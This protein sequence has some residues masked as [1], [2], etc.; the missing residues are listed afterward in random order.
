[1][2]TGIRK[3]VGVVLVLA[4]LPL[5]TVIALVALVLLAASFSS[6]SLPR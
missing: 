2:L 3:Q 5:A 1:M 6:L 4:A